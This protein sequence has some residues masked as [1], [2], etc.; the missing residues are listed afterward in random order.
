MDTSNSWLLSRVGARLLTACA[1]GVLGW[2]IGSR[3]G[4]P[5]VMA[6]S[7]AAASVVTLSVVDTLKG[8]QL[9]DWLRT[10][11][12]SPPRL[13]GIWGEVAHR[14]HRVIR[15]RDD[16]IQL[17]RA[18]L[19]Q[20]LSAIEASPVGVLLLDARDHIT[21]I[22]PSGADHFGLDPQRDLQQRVT[23]LIR[24]PTFVQY[25]Q[26]GDYR[27]PVKCLTSRAGVSFLSVQV[28]LYGDGLKLVLSQDIT[29]RERAENMRRD[30]VANVSHE[31]RTPLTVLTGFIETLA[32]LPLTE[33]ERN[34]VIGLMTQQADRMQSLVSDLLTLAQIEG[35]PRP[36]S[37]RWL[38]VSDLMKRIE[39]DGLALSRDRHPMTFSVDAKGKTMEIAGVEGEWLSAM[40]NLVS[41]AVRY[42][43][44]GARIDVKWVTL[45]E[46]GAEF[47]VTDGGIGIPAE[48]IP[49]LTERFY[50]VDGSRSRET[51][52]T[53]LGLSIVKHVVQRHGGDL[54]ITSEPGKGS[55]F[56]LTLPSVRVRLV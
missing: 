18:R 5:I 39:T 49:R 43:P 50:R 24:Q 36:S 16:R 42:T 19:G 45:P 44:D 33:V 8:H 54:K 31:I 38:R 6:F 47:S 53:G 1:G 32:S 15:L 27:E 26:A 4:H 34:R 35:S 56:T 28:R 30:F 17:E 40:G 13:P 20:F 52:G 46:G 37:D 48:H 29:E 21:W 10:P 7:G 55:T 3:T 51:G 22:S 41:N 23:N 14:V 25:L 11:E 9:L 12:V 2:W